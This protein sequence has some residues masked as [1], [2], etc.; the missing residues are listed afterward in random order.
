MDTSERVIRIGHA[1]AVVE[2]FLRARLGEPLTVDI[3]DQ[4]GVRL[5]FGLTSEMLMPRESIATGMEPAGRWTIALALLLALVGKP[6][7]LWRLT[8]ESTSGPGTS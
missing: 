7:R 5:T 4:Q 8:T 2:T 3:T 1:S 6:S